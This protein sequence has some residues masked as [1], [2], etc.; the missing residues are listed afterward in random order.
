MPMRLWMSLTA[1]LCL[2]LSLAAPALAGEHVLR[3]TATILVACSLGEQRMRCTGSNAKVA[4]R[5]N[6]GSDGVVTIEV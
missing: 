2:S 5:I 4:Y 3:V 6:T 1:P